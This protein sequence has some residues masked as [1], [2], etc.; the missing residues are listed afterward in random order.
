VHKVKMSVSRLFGNLKHVKE[1]IGTTTLG[2]VLGYFVGTLPA[3][4]ATPASLMSY[5]LAKTFSRCPYCCAVHQDGKLIQ[6]M[7]ST[8]TPGCWNGQLN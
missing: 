1:Y 5:G 4:G 2:S 3:A 8:S 7:C 6:E